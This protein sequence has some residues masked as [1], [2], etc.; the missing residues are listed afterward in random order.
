MSY[1]PTR[2]EQE[3]VIS[4]NEESDNALVDTY[5]TRL[6]SKCLEIRDV[7]IRSKETRNNKVIHLICYVPISTLSIRNPK[8]Y[9]EESRLKMSEIMKKNKG[10]HS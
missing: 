5:N 1:Q 4:F 6:I 8:Q 7:I 10:N 3:T 2:Y 9:S